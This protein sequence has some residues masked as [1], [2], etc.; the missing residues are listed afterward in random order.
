MNGKVEA[1]EFFIKDS[2][3]SLTDIPLKSLKLQSG[4]LLACIVRNGN[5]IIPNGNDAIMVGDTVIVVTTTS[6]IK[7]IREILK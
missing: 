2:I 6:Q 1:L 4:I 7:E 5:V 3:K